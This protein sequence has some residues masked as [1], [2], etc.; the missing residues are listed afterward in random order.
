MYAFFLN[1]YANRVHSSFCWG[2]RQVLKGPELVCRQMLWVQTYCKEWNSLL[3][4][5]VVQRM[6]PVQLRKVHE[7]NSNLLAWDGKSERL[8]QR[9]VSLQ[10]TTVYYS[11][12]HCSDAAEIKNRM[13]FSIFLRS[14]ER[15][16]IFQFPHIRKA[17]LWTITVLLVCKLYEKS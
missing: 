14:I 15:K 7:K 13:F 4:Y 1:L 6:L 3:A 12:L 11:V 16:N 2:V 10:C 8:V 9:K 5:T 17:H